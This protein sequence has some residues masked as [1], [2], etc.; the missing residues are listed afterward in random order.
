MSHLLRPGGL[1]ARTKTAR[2]ASSNTFLS[3]FCVNAEHSRYLVA[4]M[5]LAIAKPCWY[6]KI[7]C[8]RLSNGVTGIFSNNHST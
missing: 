7:M 8:C 1:V 2:I 3:P 6:L 5:S 4:F